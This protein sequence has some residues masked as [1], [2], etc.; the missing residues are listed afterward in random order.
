MGH[1]VK[2]AKLKLS[3]IV[4]MMYVFIAG[5]AYGIEDMIGEAGPGMTILL[6]LLLPVVWGLPFGLISAE[7]GARYPQE[8]GIY[9]WVKKALGRFW[10]FQTGWSFTLC[11]I[12][13]TAVYLVLAVGYLEWAIGIE[14]S[15]VQSWLICIGLSV[16][17]GLLNVKGIEA[18]GFSSIVFVIITLL[19]F[20]AATVLGL[21]Q[22]EFNPVKPLIPEGETVFGS[23]STAIL[24][25]MWMYSGY[26]TMS[27]FGDE[28]EDAKS[29]IPKALLWVMPIVALSYIL[30]TLVG[31]G[32]VGNWQDWSTEGPVSYIE[33]GAMIGGKALGF[34]F[35]ISAVV[36]NLSIYSGYL[37]SCAR[38]PYVMA[39]DNLFFRSF[40]KVHPKYGTPYVAILVSTIVIAIC[41]YGSF[42]SLIVIDMFLY[43]IPLVMMFISAI[44]LRYREGNLEGAY[45][46]P[47][48]N[49]LFIVIAAV[50]TVIALYAL[51]ADEPVYWIAGGLT[52]LTGVPAY[53]IF[54]R[55][56]GRKAVESR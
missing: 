52:A 18:L 29:L 47:V 1:N 37:A 41:C 40:T 32:A 28:V 26:E 12:V 36:S 14:L 24:I 34:G 51:F 53:F 45:R 20:L 11:T 46:I 49:R 17:F 43:L 5:G 16:V 4:F 35:L 31:I 56:Y 21:G 19:P 33:M 7:L 13:D 3:T 42:E 6:L 22:L 54:N 27:T 23:L 48:S 15:P 50:P 38:I 10:G 44:I 25:G 30:P 2:K 9:V 55:V 39:Q 8:G